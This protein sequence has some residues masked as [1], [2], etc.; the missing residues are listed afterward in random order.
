[1]FLLSIETRKVIDLESHWSMEERPYVPYSKNEE[2]YERHFR[3]LLDQ[4]PA[5][6]INLSIGKDV[7]LEDEVEE[8]TIKVL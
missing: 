5:K 8:R 3:K 6:D 4:Y 1:M 2:E 7:P